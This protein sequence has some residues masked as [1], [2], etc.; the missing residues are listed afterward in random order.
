MVIRVCLTSLD[1]ETPLSIGSGALS[2]DEFQ[3][4]IS[5]ASQGQIEVIF[6]TRGINKTDKSDDTKIIHLRK[7]KWLPLWISYTIICF[8][9]LPVLMKQDVLVNHCVE[10]DGFFV[11]LF[12]KLFEKKSMITIHGHYEEEWKMLRHYSKLRTWITK[13]MVS[14][15]LKFADM[16]VT[17]N[18]KIKQE[19]V[20]KGVSPSR[21]SIRYVFVDT[22]KFSRKHIDVE[23]FQLFKSNYGL[24]DK[25][26]L[27]IGHLDARDGSVD[28]VKVFRRIHDKLP[29]Y[30]CVMVGEGPL[31]A[32][33]D[34]FIIENSFNNDIIQIDKVNHELMPYLY[35]GAEILILPIHPPAA[36]VGKI[37][38]EALSM[39]VPV[40]VNDIPAGYRVVINDETGYR[41]PEG[42]M[43]LMASKAIYLLENPDLR[44]KFGSNGRKLVQ[45][46]NDIN[47]YI[48]NWVNS[49]R[50]LASES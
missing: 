40:I 3:Q 46:K 13:T 24:P 2:K 17:I 49:I 15:T 10:L 30:K 41:I 31:K 43:N 14:F 47:A 35:Y 16:I 39:E 42:N 32:Q 4:R 25:Y 7:L 23:K 9:N 26:I 48:N 6:M 50:S 1:R 28:M 29:A 8:K 38:L 20:D 19:H 5:R 36:G 22:E 44:R 11:C 37:R 45:A 18:E 12:C 34:S 27:Y 33:L 21:L